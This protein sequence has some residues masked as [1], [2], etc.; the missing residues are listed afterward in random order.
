MATSTIAVGQKARVATIQRPWLGYG[1][2]VALALVFMYGLPLLPNLNLDIAYGDMVKA[3]P[4]SISARVA[5]WLGDWGDAQFYKSWL[6]AL[7]LLAG[8]AVA[9]YL[10]R[11]KSKYKG[12]GISYGTGLW[13]QILAAQ[14]IASVISNVLFIPMLWNDPVAAK[15]AWWPTFIP[16]C[17]LAAGAVLS[18]GGDWKKVVTAGVFGGLVGGPGSW[19]IIKYICVPTGMPVAVG[20]V[21]IMVIAS[22]LF[23]ETFQF[24]PWMRK[25]EVVLGSPM[26]PPAEP[27]AAPTALAHEGVNQD[28]LFVRRVFAD[29][30]ECLFYGSDVAAMFMVVGLII[31]FMLN[32]LGP[33]YGTGWLGAVL[34]SQFLASGFGLMLYWHRYKTLGW[35][36]TFVPVVTLGPAAVMIYGPHLYVVVV[37]AIFGGMFGQPIAQYIRNVMPK[38]WP[39]YTGAVSAML[40][41]TLIF[42]AVMQVLPWFGQPGLW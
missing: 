30:N 19:F 26:A 27:A 22:I 4:T 25:Q 39:G 12:F 2:T 8:S 34:A 41:I 29:L 42:I 5:W 3:L 20:N 6:G 40:I 15:V 11:T 1:I 32:P 23:H 24:V 33:A 10:E 36:D 18:F 9:W 35:I 7:F 31:A 13:P 21:G 14:L 17:S 37:A 28:W 38:H 16:I